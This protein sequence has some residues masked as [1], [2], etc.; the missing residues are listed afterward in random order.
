MGFG[1]R[2][3]HAK[4]P[5]DSTVLQST[6]RLR[7]LSIATHGLCFFRASQLITYPLLNPCVEVR[8]PEHRAC[9]TCSTLQNFVLM[10]DRKL[11]HVNSL[12]TPSNWQLDRVRA[13]RLTTRPCARIRRK[14]TSTARASLRLPIRAWLLTILE[15]HR[16]HICRNGSPSSAWL[17]P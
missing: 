1:T 13:S 12:S 4:H 16:L 3:V 11:E 8:V 17:N 14:M 9:Q 6:E 15:V 5:N 7:V 2:H 10:F